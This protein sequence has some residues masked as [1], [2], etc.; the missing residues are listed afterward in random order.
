MTKSSATSRCQLPGTKSSISSIPTTSAGAVP[1]IAA[2]ADR[3]L[4]SETVEVR[5]RHADGSWRWAETTCTNQMHE[6]AVRGVVGNFRDVTERRRI[7][8]LGRGRRRCSNGSSPARPVPGDAA[9]A[10][11]GG[12]RV[13]RRRVGD[14]PPVRRRHRRLHRVAAPSLAPELHR[15]DGRSLAVQATDAAEAY[16]SRFEPI[17][18]GDIDDDPRFPHM[19]RAPPAGA[20][21]GLPCVLVGA[22]P[23]ARR[24]RPPRHAGDLRAQPPWSRPM[25][26]RR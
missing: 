20:S 15:R 24:Q 22:D 5:C 16:N 1:A 14:D 8:T 13:S 9:R 11:G 21:A 6:P 3:P 7:E 12:R 26:S 2:L 23:H 10:P 25:P 19:Q 17:I 4:E 18:I